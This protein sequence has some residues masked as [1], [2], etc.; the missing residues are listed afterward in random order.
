MSSVSGSVSD[1]GSGSGK[2]GEFAELDQDVDVEAGL[3]LVNPVGICTAV[4]VGLLAVAPAAGAVGRLNQYGCFAVPELE[5]E[6]VVLRVD[7][8]L[9]LGEKDGKSVGDV[10]FWDE[11]GMAVET[12]ERCMVPLIIGLF[13]FNQ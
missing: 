10:I 13:G 11:M 8:L 9:L 1:S 4:D 2:D 5:A 7:V 6:I 12:S 3:L